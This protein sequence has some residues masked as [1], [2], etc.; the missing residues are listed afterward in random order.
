MFDSL[1]QSM[2]GLSLRI[3]VEQRAL[4]THAR[5][6][7]DDTLWLIVAMTVLVLLGSYFG[8]L[9]TRR[10]VIRPIRLLESEVS[11]VASGDVDHEVE[12]FGRGDFLARYQCRAHEGAGS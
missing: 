8:W 4:T 5:S 1:R 3:G 2:S 9:L 11:M 10:W 6:L 12:A 7:Q